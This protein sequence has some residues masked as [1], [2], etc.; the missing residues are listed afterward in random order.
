M[1]AWTVESPRLGRPARDPGVCEG[2]SQRT[3]Y[4]AVRSGVEIACHDH[5]TWTVHDRIGRQLG[6]SL[7]LGDAVIGVG[8]LVLKAGHDYGKRAARMG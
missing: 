2:V 5:R 4:W 6:Q 1:D 8:D 7:R 3:Q